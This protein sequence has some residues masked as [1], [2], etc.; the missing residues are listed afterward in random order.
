MCGDVDARG[1]RSKGLVLI[2]ENMNRLYLSENVDPTHLIVRL[3]HPLASS[4]EDQF[5]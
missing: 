1:R 3:H 5:L 4:Q 2:G